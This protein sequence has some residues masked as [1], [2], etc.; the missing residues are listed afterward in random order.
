MAGWEQLGAGLRGAS[1]GRERNGVSSGY[2][3][4]ATGHGGTAA[5]RGGAP[6][7][8]CR[9]LEEG[10]GDGIIL[11]TPWSLHFSPEHLPPAAPWP[12]QH[13]RARVVQLT[14]QG[15]RRRALRQSSVGQFD[16]GQCQDLGPRLLQS[17]RCVAGVERGALL[18]STLL[19][20]V[21]QGRLGLGF[22]SSVPLRTCFG[23]APRSQRGGKEGRSEGRRDEGR[24]GYVPGVP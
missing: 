10:F 23:R 21:G 2:S 11:S 4:R 6:A 18:A 5:P 14:G 8:G 12:E 19:G 3:A 17:C 13:G 20:A 16:G 7:S 9:S 22:G 1:V 15:S 24:G